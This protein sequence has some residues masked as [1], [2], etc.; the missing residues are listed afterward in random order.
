MRFSAQNRLDAL[1]EVIRQEADI[2]AA[3]AYRT[4]VKLN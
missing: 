4:Y 3:Q 2:R 1:A